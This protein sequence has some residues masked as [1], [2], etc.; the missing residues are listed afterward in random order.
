MPDGTPAAA[1]PHS[2]TV[3]LRMLSEADADVGP[4]HVSLVNVIVERHG[5]HGML[6]PVVIRLVGGKGPRGRT[7]R[8]AWSWT[9]WGTTAVRRSFIYM[10]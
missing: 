7:P 4:S 10:K 2:L 1:S 3:D 6:M 9:A 5:Q 8:P